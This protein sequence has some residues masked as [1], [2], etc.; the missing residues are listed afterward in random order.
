MKPIFYPFIAIL[1]FFAIAPVFAQEQEN[2]A[3]YYVNSFSFNIK[4]ITS[5]NA[6]LRNGELKVGELLVGEAKLQKYIA[7]KTQLLLNQ[8]VL[9]KVSMDYT[10][11]EVR[12]DG[13]YPVDFTINTEDTWNI[14]AIPY[15][16]Y[17]SNT[18]FSLT[19]K[20]RDY[21]FLGGMN[22]LS[23]DL[24]Y[25]YN[26]KHQSSLIVSLESDTPFTALGYNW[27][28]TFNNYFNYRPNVSQPYF[29]Q[30]TTGL[31]MDLPYKRTTFTFG[32]N[33][34][35][36]LNQENAD[37]YKKE[38]GEFQNGLYM[39]TNPV[40]SWKIPT[41]VFI[42]NYGEL[43]YTP[44]ISATINHQFPQWP[45]AD[46][47]IGPVA[48]FSHTL[49]FS[50]V[51][52]IN[53]YR[54]GFDVS[55]S[56]SYDYDFHYMEKG[57]EALNL[58]Y[59]AAAKGYFIISERFGFSAFL[60]F[61]QWLYHNPDYYDTG[62]D[63]LRGILDNAIHANYMLSLNMDFPVRVLKFMPSEWFNTQSLRF[64]NFEL[65]IS[66]IIDMALF[67]G[68]LSNN[69][70]AE[71]Y[72]NVDFNFR[73]MLVSGGFEAIVFPEFMRSLYLR[74]SI[75]WNITDQINHPRDY[76]LTPILPIVPH[77]PVDKYR[78]IFI[79]LG[80]QY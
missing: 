45:L 76:Y 39:T 3:V 74:I 21:N 62:G 57:P 18:G 15:P 2:G 40:I 65:H 48:S 27:Y 58:S 5:P 55:L 30:N 75:A 34:N 66:P 79:G 1:L 51:D 37:R 14:I 61:R 9:K 54:R 35:V 43:T 36:Y 47:L 10:I 7:D 78:E 31:A 19:L 24:G 77:L 32:L 23:L 52:W 38:Y 4:G 44:Q 68:T 49:G 12:P 69:K 63:A 25:Q 26:E 28:L 72:M 13:A 80:H 59:T 42:G 71:K 67:K 46:F 60:Q 56:N 70:S 8:R 50:Q 16:K 20:A 17:D 53:N 41:G 64:F 6:I 33:E 73:D 22:P 11:G 29:Y